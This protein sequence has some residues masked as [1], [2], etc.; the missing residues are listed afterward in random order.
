MKILPSLRIRL[1]PLLLVLS[2]LSSCLPG[3][4][5]NPAGEGDSGPVQTIPPAT[6]TAI[7]EMA[8]AKQT[9]V[10]DPMGIPWSELEGLELEFWYIWDLDEPGAGVNAIVDRFNRENE[11]GITVKAVDQG[12]VLDPIGSVEEAFKEGLVPHVM[13]VESSAIAGWYDDGVIIDLTDLLNDPA[14]GLPPD[15]QNS[16]YPGIFENLSITG[17]DRPG[18]PFSQSLQV[19]YYNQSWADELGYHLP[20]L[21]GEDFLKQSCTFA[22]QDSPL[23]IVLSP[24]A[25]NILSQLY[26]Y[27]GILLEPGE[28][29]YQFESPEMVETAKDWQAL[30]KKG[31]GKGIAN[32]PNPMALEME[33]DRFNTRGTLMIMGSTE[34]MAH[35]HTGANQTGRADDWT[36]LP[37]F[38]PG[39]SKAVASDLQTVVVFKTNPQEQLAAWLFTRYLVSPEVQAEWVQYS[40]FYPTRKDSLW[41]LRDFRQENPHWADGLNLLKYSSSIPLDPTWNTVQLALEDAFE[42]ILANPDLDLQDQ[43]EI[44]AE[45]TAELRTKSGE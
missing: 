44:L 16:F 2:L 31:C 13:L 38:G 30:S 42:E 1:L 19:I 18:M 7:S 34:M 40:G 6:L 20:P 23:G 9:E 24:Q 26:A 35:I 12:L 43:L 10:P 32:Y 21:T 22:G 28:D 8:A 36:I 4:S 29:Q 11:W 41:F 39:G 37:F 15:E 25:E 3:T 45:V 17:S 5:V 14:A 27:Q 33:F